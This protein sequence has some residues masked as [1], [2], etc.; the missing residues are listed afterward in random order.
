MKYAK[1]FDNMLNLIFHG[2]KSFRAAISKFLTILVLN[3]I[4]E[5]SAE[6]VYKLLDLFINKLNT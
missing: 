6:E 2:E 5:G 3:S 1:D 4:K